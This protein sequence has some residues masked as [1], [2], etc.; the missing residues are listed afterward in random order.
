M[1][2]VIGLEGLRYSEIAVFIIILS[3]GCKYH[4]YQSIVNMK[5][6]EYQRPELQFASK[7]MSF[8]AY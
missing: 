7:A 4:S 6:E 5:L 1:G 3:A 8:M 2:G